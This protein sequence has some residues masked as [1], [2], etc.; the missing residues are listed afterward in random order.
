MTTTAPDRSTE[1]VTYGGATR[2]QSSGLFGVGSAGFFIICAGG[3]FGLLCM[4]LLSWKVAVPIFLL[5]GAGYVLLRVRNRRKQTML[6]AA[7]IASA[8][9]SG[10]RG[11]RTSYRS[12]PASPHPW[13]TT[14]LPGVLANSELLSI[15]GAY[16]EDI[17]VI[18]YPR[19]GHYVAVLTSTPD[20]MDMRDPYQRNLQVGYWAAFQ[21]RLCSMRELAGAQFVVEASPDTGARLR[22]DLAE[23][24]SD[25]ATEVELKAMEQVANTYPQ[26]SP[27]VQQWT[28]LTFSSNLGHDGE[29]RSQ[30]E[31]L[32]WLATRLPGIARDLSAT[33]AGEVRAVTPEELCEEIRSAYDPTVASLLDSAALDGGA[34]LSWT[35]VGPTTHEDQPWYYEHN[36]N[37]S[38]SWLVTDPPQGEVYA[39]ALRDMLE[40]AEGID[41]KR[42]V[43]FLRPYD[44]ARAQ[45]LIA[46]DKRT[47]NFNYNAQGGEKKAPDSV[48]AAYKL[49]H[50][51]GREHQKGSGL[52]DFA[53]VITA[54]VCP[55]PPMVRT[56]PEEDWRSQEELLELRV[57]R[58]RSA[59]ENM[60]ASSQ[61]AAQ[62]AHKTQAWAFA[63]SLPVG[64]VVENHLATPA[65]ARRHLS[66]A[67]S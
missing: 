44:S 59:I 40:P 24:A 8:Y 9:S 5:V 32:K 58:A 51:R 48:Q 11:G 55:P 47:A 4:L 10:R 22:R 25:T 33:G 27:S 1:E 43:L 12:G 34:K 29:R 57:A 45:R 38:T 46:A 28:A 52:L 2:P 60:A 13:G 17:A 39:G 36:G 63:L 65:A 56:S 16:G 66:G 37:I 19:L 6:Q 21:T 15:P 30:R 20:G 26:A 31:V 50:Q 41:R 61:L 62:P 14:A 42:F 18:H 54:T 7:G 49:A 67:A 64:I 35:Q 23:R 3:L 53:A